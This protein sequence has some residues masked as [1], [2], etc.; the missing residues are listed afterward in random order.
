MG[1]LLDG[2][3]TTEP[4]VFCWRPVYLHVKKLMLLPYQPHNS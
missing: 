2:I 4:I 3:N 1:D